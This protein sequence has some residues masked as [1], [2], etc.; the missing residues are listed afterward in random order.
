M[1]RRRGTEERLPAGGEGGSTYEQTRFGV[2]EDGLLVQVQP[3][4]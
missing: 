2:P 1:K 4:V 3:V